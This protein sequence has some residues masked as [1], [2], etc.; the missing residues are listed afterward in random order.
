MSSTSTTG[1]LLQLAF[2]L[3]NRSASLDRHLLASS[4]RSCSSSSA[5]LLTPSSMRRTNLTLCTSLSKHVWMCAVISPPPSCQ[6]SGEAL[7][8]S[9]TSQR[10]SQSTTCRE[11]SSSGRDRTAL[12]HRVRHVK[13]PPGSRGLRSATS[14]WAGTTRP[15]R[16]SLV[17][18]SRSRAYQGLSFLSSFPSPSGGAS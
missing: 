6:C 18:P 7:K 8:P 2:C 10:L 17:G 9:C 14:I 1:S 5:S 11:P 16:G 15:S 13:P 12:P 4:S 3:A